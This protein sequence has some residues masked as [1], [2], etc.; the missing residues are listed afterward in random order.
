MSI[1]VKDEEPVDQRAR[2]LSPLERDIVNKQI[3]EWIDTDIVRPSISEYTSPVKKKN[4]SMRLC[5]D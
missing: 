4:G 2:R 1:V 5:V 3:R